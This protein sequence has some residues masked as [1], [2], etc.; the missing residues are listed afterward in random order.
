[1]VKYDGFIS[2]SHAAD[3][4][5]AS[6]VQRALHSF[7]K[8]W[9]QLR[10]LHIYR[11]ATSL[12]ATPELWGAIV[13]ALAKS[14][15]F[16]LFA[17]PEAA[18]SG[19]VQKEIEWWCENRD[20]ERI[21][22]LLTDGTIA[23]NPEINDF[24][25]ERTT[26]LPGKLKD[27]F[28]SEPLWVDLTFARSVSD[29]T[30]HNP[31]FYQAILDLAAPLNGRPKDELG[32]ADVREHRKTRRI[33][34]AAITALVALMI[35]SV[36]AAWIATIQRDSARS[37][38][39]AAQ[40]Q[41]QLGTDPA[42]SLALASEAMTVRRTSEARQMLRSAV[43]SSH[44]D[45][46][47]DDHSG[48]ILTLEI[49]PDGPRVLSADSSGALI[50]WNAVD[51]ADRLDLE[52]YRAAVNWHSN[53]AVSVLD[54][55]SLAV[56][57]LTT[58]ERTATLTGHESTVF[59]LAISP[60]G[61][62]VASGGSDKNVLRYNLEDGER[63]GAP[64]PV[65]GS[66]T[67]LIFSPNGQYL[68]IGSIYNKM[69]LMDTATGR[70]L[71][72]T[73]GVSAAFNP[74]S[75]RLLTGGAD[76]SGEQLTPLDPIGEPVSLSGIGGSIQ[77]VAFSPDG[78]YF[79][80][81]SSE[82]TVRIWD[83]DGR[84][85]LVLSGHEGWV[86]DVTFS[87]DGQ[88]VVT[89]SKDY[90]ARI[91]SLASGRQVAILR[92][93]QGNID[94]ARFLPDARSVVT[95]SEDGS[96]RLWKI[97]MAMPH[98]TIPG[99]ERAVQK[100]RFS[101]DDRYLV[102]SSDTGRLDI[103]D[104]QVRTAVAVEDVEQFEIARGGL[105][106]AGNGADVSFM[107]MLGGRNKSIGRHDDIV[108]AVVISSDERFAIITSEDHTALLVDLD[109][110][111]EPINL[112]H[113]GGVSGAAFAP[114]Q[115]A[116]VTTTYDGTGSIWELPGGTKHADFVHSDTIISGVH[117]I[118]N[119]RFVTTSWDGTLAT[120]SVADGGRLASYRSQ[121]A[122]IYTL[123]PIGEEGR[124]I[125][126]G[127]DGGIEIWDID[128]GELFR[129]IRGHSDGIYTLAV[130][131][132][133]DLVLSAGNDGT[134]RLWALDTGVAIATYFVHG[135]AVWSVAFSNDGQSFATGSEDGDIHIYQCSICG[136]DDELLAIAGQRPG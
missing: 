62:T 76:G 99:S 71:L 121:S 10:Q 74:T 134:A 90:T 17:S 25:W 40:A 2:Y 52:G 124:V 126:G 117:F 67:D 38:E 20:P 82:G 91:W 98:T 56:W 128:S 58:G 39:L 70:I 113:D 50:I 130:H 86:T 11:D 106:V 21:F 1:V 101:P 79:A 57:N 110:V 49:E 83:A 48:R 92:G 36:T 37:R 60:D 47:I 116:V 88:F 68:A 85:D 78:A 3:G 24:D 131:P 53:S 104:R 129:R 7:A 120:W 108:S 18:A 19:W 59:A 114:D 9:Y 26:A 61:K 75:T 115:N 15:H 96:V 109:G 4:N 133:R 45:F 107:D 95:G 35:A 43:F 34:G 33:A 77:S 28:S 93:H 22:I 136:G 42:A 105:V 122:Q 29:L 135:D 119:D 27:M 31:D 16:L 81:A 100:L 73:T 65:G 103:W 30:L 51:P 32:G 66:V 84:P 112:A 94:F 55:A 102:A 6:F 64:L 97:D 12:S 118:D 54:D 41:L 46:I 13:A 72:E 123:A 63:I 8:P 127:N 5:L 132:E 87:Q 80:A 69:R 44:L 125:L 14:R 89:A 23:W 111:L